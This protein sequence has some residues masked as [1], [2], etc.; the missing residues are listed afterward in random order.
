MSFDIQ[1]A[2]RLI[3]LM[4]QYLQVTV[5]LSIFTMVIGLTIAFVIALITDAKIK[6]L[7]PLLKVYV[8]FFRGTP[9]LAQLFLLYFGLAQV[10]PVLIKLSAFNA[11]L[12]VLS[13]NSA[14][15]MSEAI[16][17]A[18]MS[19][20]KGQMEACLSIGMTYWQSMRRIILPQAIRTAV[21][22]LSN[23]FI[24]IVKS[25]SLAYT[26]GVTEMMAMAQMEAASSYRYLEAFVV[27]ILVY[28]LIISVLGH[29]QNKLEL[30]LNE[31]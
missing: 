11:A 28:W 10:F 8:S 12:I 22:A 25:S 21:P 14:A 24:N 9:L 6:I 3:P 13:L 29:M 7:S 2:I 30:R 17:G 20:E 23:S 18:I 1:F 31:Y 15:F 5:I 26:I 4:L 27:I 19:V 16:R